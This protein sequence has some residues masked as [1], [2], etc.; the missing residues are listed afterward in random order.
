MMTHSPLPS[1]LENLNDFTRQL[2]DL[3]HDAARDGRP[4]HNLELQ[5]WKVLLQLGRNAIA[6]FLGLIGNGDLGPT[7]QT[8]D[9]KTHTR[10]P[11]T[12][13][14]R[15][16]S[17]FG[18]FRIDRVVYGSREGQQIDFVPVDTRLQLPQSDFSY[19]L[20][21]W[22]QS[23]A[24]EQSYAQVRDT[25]ARILD[26][27]QSVDSLERMTAGMA[28][29]TEP[30]RDGQ[31]PP[32]PA[33]EGEVLVASA[34][35]KGIVL[36]RPADAPPAKAHRT[37]G[38][39]A[40]L[41][42]MA[43]VGAVYTVDRYIRTPQQVVEALFADRLGEPPPKRPQACH[44]RVWAGLSLGSGPEG[45]PTTGTE[46]VYTWLQSEVIERNRDFSKEMVYLHDGQVSLWDACNT[47]LPGKN[48]TEILDLLHVTP[49]LW[50]AAHVFELEGGPKVERFVREALLKV[51]RGRVEGVLRS[52]QGL[53]RRSKLSASKKRTLKGVISY[54][55]KNRE[56]MR[57]DEY[58][59]KGY[60][61]ASGVIEGACR[62]LVKDRMERAGMHWR[63][64]G[65]QAL[66]D[67]RS[68]ALNGQW[69]AFQTYRVERANRRLYPHR[70]LVEGANFP[71]AA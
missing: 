66:L 4:L 7:V 34:D 70:N 49:R 47:Y 60:P 12:H 2:F 45:R 8:E 46:R 50:Q 30:F 29:A 6:Q 51:L 13:P 18:A 27:N 19:L 1:N 59:S 36:R 11:E 41:K 10:L 64:P 56:R 22:D 20:Q 14:R 26:L 35:G 32:P 24:V 28:E 5:I 65:A 62:H 38:D 67:V 15:Y 21:D 71:I 23:L 57:Y 44:K 58:L 68:V 55:R 48:A 17:I 31:P 25:I 39:K 16:V 61:I 9:G 43:I 37:K 52:W 42:R 40:S 54:L 69:E 53:A 33:E 63:E 3:V